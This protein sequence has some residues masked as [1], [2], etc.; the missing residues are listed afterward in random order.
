MSE[1]GNTNST[2]STMGSFMVYSLLLVMVTFTE[3][4]VGNEE[5]VYISYLLYVLFY[6]H[7]CVCCWSLTFGL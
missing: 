3:A 2:A 4:A 6:V 5:Y 1:E 7:K